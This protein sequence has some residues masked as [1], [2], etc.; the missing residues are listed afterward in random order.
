M[1][2]PAL[3]ALRQN[4]GSMVADKQ[5]RGKQ[6]QEVEMKEERRKILWRELRHCFF[7]PNFRKDL[8]GTSPSN[9]WGQDLAGTSPAWPTSNIKHLHPSTY[10]TTHTSI[11]RR[12]LP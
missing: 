2:L 11:Q 6:E 12:C 4:A 10:D 5:A 9:G 3:L 1:P 7:P 8:A